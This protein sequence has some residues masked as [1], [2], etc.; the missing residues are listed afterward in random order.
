MYAIYSTLFP[1]KCVCTHIRRTPP[2]VVCAYGGRKWGGGCLDGALYTQLSTAAVNVFPN[3]S[4]HNWLSTSL[5]NCLDPKNLNTR[6]SYTSICLY[7]YSLIHKYT[8]SLMVCVLET[9][10]YS[11][12][13]TLIDFNAHCW[14]GVTMYQ[15]CLQGYSILHIFRVRRVCDRWTMTVT[16]RPSQDKCKSVSI[17]TSFSTVPPPTS[18]LL[19]SFFCCCWGILVVRTPL[20]MCVQTHFFG[21][22]CVCCVYREIEKFITR[23][24]PMGEK[25]DYDSEN[26]WIFF[27]NLRVFIKE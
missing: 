18:H 3:G 22:V 10:F 13:S 19:S 27:F 15:S 9:G 14:I 5:I 11:S 25:D 2:G 12:W 24:P 17:F 6:H 7:T 16:T 20:L 26:S 21:T 1:K 4:N 8:Y 23:Q